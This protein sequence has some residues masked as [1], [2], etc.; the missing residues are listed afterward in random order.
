MVRAPK[1][2][3]VSAFRSWYYDAGGQ[4]LENLPKLAALSVESEGPRSTF[5]KSEGKQAV[6]STD[7]PELTQIVRRIADQPTEALLRSTALKQLPENVISG[8]A[9]GARSERKGEHS[10]TGVTNRF[11]SLFMTPLDAMHP[12][13]SGRSSQNFENDRLAVARLRAFAQLVGLGFV[14][15]DYLKE[16]LQFLDLKVA[17]NQPKTVRSEKVVN[18]L[19]L[20][21]NE[22]TTSKSVTRSLDAGEQITL[23]TLIDLMAEGE[24]KGKPFGLFGVGDAV[25]KNSENADSQKFMNLVN[26]IF[27]DPKARAKY[28]LSKYDPN[29]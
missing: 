2:L 11:K 19:S 12:F 15:A 1:G 3:D 25:I 24:L 13:L 10:G 14:R 18:L 23:N 6:L 22:A 16:V 27:R 26:E 5:Q 7:N 20:I 8:S 28:G 21:M 9:D 17:A 4:I 29:G